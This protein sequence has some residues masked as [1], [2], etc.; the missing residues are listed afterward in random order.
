M[1][2]N[3]LYEAENI[4]CHF[5]WGY[6]Y[7]TLS[8]NSTYNFISKMEIDSD[9]PTCVQAR[10]KSDTGKDT[11][12]PLD[13]PLNITKDQL[14]LICNALLQEVNKTIFKHYTI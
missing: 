7:E 14:Q 3:T 5:D 2:L 1:G 4:P 9:L 12:S 10:L 13:L 6:V 11:G 8:C